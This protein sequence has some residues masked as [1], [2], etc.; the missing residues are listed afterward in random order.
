MKIALPALVAAL[1]APSVVFAQDPPRA[2]APG[3]DAPATVVVPR[4]TVLFA[5]VSGRVESDEASFPAPILQGTSIH[6]DSDLNVDDGV[7]AWI[8]EIVAFRRLGDRY[9]ELGSLSWL[10]ANYNGSST[11]DET[12]FFNGRTFTAGT[13]VESKVRYRSWGIDYAVVSGDMPMQNTSG[14]FRL[15][16]RY[17][18]LR[19]QMEGGGQETDERLRLFY[20]GGGLRGEAHWGGWLTGLIQGSVYFSFGGYDDYWDLEYEEWGGTI[21]EGNVGVS[22]S[23][24]TLL[25]EGGWRYLSNSSYSKTD[26]T[27]KFEDNDF[28]LELSGPYA[29]VSIRF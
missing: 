24:G 15:G 3:P 7:P 9:D 28:T 13:Q 12:Q 8:A 11:F 6:Y 4:F 19:I 29:S 25:L 16:A 18:D 17:T 14:S 20:F 22:A 10:E 1:V 23:L 27:E 2:P 5:D 26:S 21:F